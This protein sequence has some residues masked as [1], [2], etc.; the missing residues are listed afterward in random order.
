MT[1][2]NRREYPVSSAV[3]EELLDDAQ[4]EIDEI[5]RRI[6]EGEKVTAETMVHIYARAI[7][8]LEM[9]LR[10]AVT[11]SMARYLLHYA[12]HDDEGAVPGTVEF[13]L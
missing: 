7:C 8:R 13:P 10:S 6:G 12:V 2:S 4:V 9:G 11:D 1:T 3:I 5:N